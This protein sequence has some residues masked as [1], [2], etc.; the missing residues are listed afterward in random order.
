M[1]IYAPTA[2]KWLA[3]VTLV[4]GIVFL[5]GIILIFAKISNV[6]FSI[7]FTL[8]GGLLGMLFLIC[9]LA[10]RTRV[11]SI[12]NE[13]IIL[14]RGVSI[15]GKM[16]FQKTVVKWSEIGSVKSNFLPGDKII[17]EDCFFHTLG[18]KDGRKV[19]F[20]LFSYGKD[21]EKDILE[22]IKRNIV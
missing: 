15:N 4:C 3:A 19:T 17:S 8:L 11:L 2:L 18:L 22:T 10:E 12:D 21:E 20:T 7:G 9:Y 13:K 5:S 16:V 6:S 1:K 14:P